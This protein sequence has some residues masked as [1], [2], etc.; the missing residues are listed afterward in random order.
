MK[1]MKTDDYV[2]NWQANTKIG[3][4]IMVALISVILA[5]SMFVNVLMILR[6]R[7]KLEQERF[8][9][10]ITIKSSYNQNDDEIE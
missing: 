3:A 5:A 6:N 8:S 9:S 10:Y 7:K 4:V 1:L 2:E